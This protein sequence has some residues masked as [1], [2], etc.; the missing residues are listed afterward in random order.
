MEHKDIGNFIAERRKA[1]G[2]TQK[3]LAEKLYVSDKAISKWER[4]LVH[5][6]DDH[7]PF[8][9]WNIFKHFIFR[10]PDYTKNTDL[11]HRII[12]IFYSHHRMCKTI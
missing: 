1:K 5:P 12:N 2:L 11:Y 6:H 7:L 8:L 10:Y 4:Y 3:Q 9:F